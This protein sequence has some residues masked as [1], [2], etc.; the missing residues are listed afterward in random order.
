MDREGWRATVH[1]VTESGMTEHACTHAH[2]QTS[3][4]KKKERGTEGRRGEG[5]KWG[6]VFQERTEEAGERKD[7]KGM[8]LME[9]PPYI[10]KPHCP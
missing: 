5:S 2:T 9:N 1:G 7:T 6:K 4:L 10:G 3:T 8:D